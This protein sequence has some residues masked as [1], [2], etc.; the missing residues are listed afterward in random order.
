M[1]L[2][3]SILLSQSEWIYVDSPTT[4]KI[5]RIHCLDSLNCWAAGDSG[6]I[7][8][9]STGGTTWEIQDAGI[10]NNILDIFFLNNNL[11]WA[12]AIKFDEPSGSFI[13]KTT[14]GGVSWTSRLFDSLNVYFFTVNFL[15]SLTGFLAG[16]PSYV[17]YRTSD[18]GL[19]WNT[20]Q[21]DSSI[22]SG[23]P[24]I[25][26][27]FYS[28]QYGFACGGQRD[29]VGV[30][31]KTTDYG[32][33]WS[34]YDLGP[35][36]L[37]ELFVLDSLN[38]FGVGGDYEYGAGVARTTNAGISWIYFEPGV[39]GVA[40]GLS[41]RTRDEGWACITGE[42]KFLVTTNLGMTWEIRLAPDLVGI[43]DITFTDS[44]HGLAVGD[45]GVILKYNPFPVNVNEGGTPLPNENIL[46]QNYPNPFNPSTKISWQSAV[47]SWQTLK[48]YDVLG[49]EIVTLV[50]EYKPAGNYEVEFN[51]VETH[52]GVS[53]PSGISA[54]GGYASGVYF[55]R[56]KA[57]D[58]VETKKMLLL[59]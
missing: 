41:F 12:V 47:S 43:N 18:G 58:Y 45:G 57:G 52:H 32:F 33:S 54:K 31:W 53:L 51:T 15:D 6:L 8:H 13:L 36:P 1:L 11:G 9:T 56:L 42:G 26:L 20:V 14:N 30:I 48:I 39:F 2:K 23:L 40:T 22:F 55:Y 29:V 21:F 46:L 49:N 50:D 19:T 5:W 7:I 27:E 59:R 24:I 28:K 10:Y 35:E 17:F 25:D 44:L 16:A 3:N 38:I 34:S 37:T 4:K